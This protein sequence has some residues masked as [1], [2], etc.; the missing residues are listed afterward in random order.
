MDSEIKDTSVI[1]DKKKDEMLYLSSKTSRKVFENES[2]DKKPK[3]S[4]DL[5]S[6]P[7][8][9]EPFNFDWLEEPSCFYHLKE[10][11]CFDHSEK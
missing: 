9:F 7:I 10:S 5:S 8:A 3:L 1:L 11:P 2:N 4:F 6:K